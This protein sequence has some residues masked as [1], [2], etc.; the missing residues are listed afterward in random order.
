M[1]YKCPCCGHYTFIEPTGNTYDIC[2]VCFWED[3]GWQQDNPDEAGGANA[4]SLNQA[5]INYQKFGACT[6]KMKQYARAADAKDRICA[7]ISELLVNRGRIPYPG[8]SL[9]GHLEVYC[10][11]Y[12][13][14]GDPDGFE[15]IY[16]PVDEN[17]LHRALSNKDLIV[18]VVS[19]KAGF[20]FVR[21]EM[22]DK[23]REDTKDYRF[24]YIR[25]DSLTEENLACAHPE[26]LPQE[27][28]KIVWINDDFM[29]DDSID[30]DYEAFELIDS[31][32]DYLNPA[33]FS[34]YDFAGICDFAG[35]RRKK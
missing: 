9:E 28:Q 19:E 3:D 1:K 4:V 7:D 10:G 17:N 15:Y 6:P 5:R 13:V 11:R 32:I 22:Y 26:Q 21:D 33:H 30:F 34:M 12:F 20:A 2:P 23:F 31:G 14:R 18:A 35:F 24:Q 27:Y 16:W 8:L 25:L 29:D